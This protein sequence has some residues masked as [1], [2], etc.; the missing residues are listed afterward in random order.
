MHSIRE[1]ALC[2]E[3]ALSEA[4]N[5]AYLEN[6]KYTLAYGYKKVNVLNPFETPVCCG[7]EFSAKDHLKIN[8]LL[9]LLES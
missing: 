1:H 3:Q 8:S 2:S 7:Y 4:S 6:I 9:S 5:S